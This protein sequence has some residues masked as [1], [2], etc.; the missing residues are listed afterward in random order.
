[1]DESNNVTKIAIFSRDISDRKNA[2][3]ALYASE[4][5]F[6]ALIENSADFVLLVDREDK[7]L[8]VSPSIERV[9]GYTYDEFMVIDKVK[10]IHPDDLEILRSTHSEILKSYDKTI[11]VQYRALTR[12][13]EYH[14]LEKSIRNLL[15]DPYVG[16]VVANVRDITATKITE[17]ALKESEKK[18]RSVIENINDIFYRTDFHGRIVMLSHSAGEM[19]N[20]SS[21]DDLMGIPLGALFQNPKNRAKMLSE[22]ENSGSVNNFEVKLLRRDRKEIDVAISSHFYY[23]NLGQ[24]LGDEG[25]IRDVTERNKAQKALRESEERFRA[26]IENAMDA[27][28]IIDVE[29]IIHFISPSVEKLFGYRPDEFIGK[30]ISEYT[31]PDDSNI[32]LNLFFDAY[33][34]PGSLSISE[35]RYKHKNG[36]WRIVEFIV[37]NLTEIPSVK[38]IVANFRDITDRKLAEEALEK[39]IIALTKPLSSDDSELKFGDIFNIDEIQKIQ[40]AFA[41]ATGV[42]SIITYTDGTPLTEPSNFCYLCNNIIRQT[43]KGCNNCYRSDAILGKYNPDGYSLQTLPEWWS[44]RWRNQYQ[45]RRKAYCQLV[46][47]SSD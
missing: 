31:H 14:Y 18:Y 32:I 38:G 43:E 24:L 44:F 47:R 5:R 28:A 13:G 29:G 15:N 8:Y 3:Q 45:R 41:A 27:I 1:M 23:D 4:Q 33:N 46:N 10:L 35:F 30:H 11:N 21:I 40:D 39:R 34:K 26:L 16:S 22:M 20:Y 7:T 17:L 6:R 42:A 2:E 19:L 12:N 25:I 9:L 37:Q 36:S